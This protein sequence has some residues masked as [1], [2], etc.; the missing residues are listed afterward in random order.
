MKN[1]FVIPTKYLYRILELFYEENLTK[2]AR[3][4][5]R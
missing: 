5:H 1:L 3:F 4:S 2:T